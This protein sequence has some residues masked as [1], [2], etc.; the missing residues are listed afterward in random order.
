[1][2]L[3]PESIRLALKALK[4]FFETGRDMLPPKEIFFKLSREFPGDIGI[5]F[6][7]LLNHLI[8]EEGECIFLGANEPHAYLSGTCIELM[9][10]SDNVVRAGLTPKFKDV[11]TLT[12][13]LTYESSTPERFMVQR[14]NSISRSISLYKPPINAFS[15][16]EIVITSKDGEFSFDGKDEGRNFESLLLITD[17]IGKIVTDNNSEFPLSIG[18]CFYV[19]SGSTFTIFN[20]GTIPIRA[21]R[22]FGPE[23]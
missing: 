20:Q 17:G 22:A 16:Q 6:A 4:D 1:M 10:S 12:N 8:L 14:D 9:T 5:L 3:N 13:M 11:P 2:N 19:G 21:Y 23:K 18:S 7:M 15:L